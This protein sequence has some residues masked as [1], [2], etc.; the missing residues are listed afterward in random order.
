MAIEGNVQLPVARGFEVRVL[1][2]RPGPHGDVRLMLSIGDMAY[3]DVFA[4]MA[5]D[6]TG[7][8]ATVEDHRRAVRVFLERLTRWQAFFQRQSSDG[9]GEEEQRGLY[10]ELWFLRHHLTLAVGAAAAIQSWTG[11]TAA[12]QD[13]QCA[14]VAYETKTAVANP[15]QKLHVANVR[16]LDRT[17]LDALFVFHLSIDQ[18]QGSGESLVQMIEAVRGLAI[19]AGTGSMVELN[20][21]LLAAGYLD[22]HA[23]RYQ[24]VGYTRRQHHFYHVRDGFPCIVERDLKTGVGD[25]RYTIAVAACQ[26]F[27]VGDDAAMAAVKGATNG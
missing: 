14:A 11:P 10:G 15:P 21:K 24:R 7:H 5:E 2:V 3:R 16:Q 9:L 8:L 12:N 27:E 4:V 6:L 23:L 13:F 19:Q 17:G 26:P 22:L 1:P 25:V 20:D 18:R